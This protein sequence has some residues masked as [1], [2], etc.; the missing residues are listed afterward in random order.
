MWEWHTTHLARMRGAFDAKTDFFFRRSGFFSTKR[1][2]AAAAAARSVAKTHRDRSL[3]SVKKNPHRFCGVR[4]AVTTATTL[5]KGIRALESASPA[6]P[7][8]VAL[9]EEKQ[10]EPLFLAAAPSA[11]GGGAASKDLPAGV[12]GSAQLA[13]GAR[14]AKL[15][16]ECAIVLMH[17]EEDVGNKAYMIEAIRVGVVD[18]VRFPLVAQSMRTLWQHAVRR[19]IRVAARETRRS[20]RPASARASGGGKRAVGGTERRSDRASADSGESTASEEG[21]LKRG[22][23]SPESVLP[24]AAPKSGGGAGTGAA[25]GGKR[26]AGA[27]G[28]SGSGSDKEAD[29]EGAKGKE[30]GGKKS[31]SGVKAGNAAAAA[32][33]P[34]GKPKPQPRS[35]QQWRAAEQRGRRLA[36]KPHTAVVGG[37][38]GVGPGSLNPGAMPG[39]GAM[40]GGGGVYYHTG[41]VGGQPGMAPGAHPHAGVL[42]Q[43][44][45]MTING[46]QVQVWVPMNASGGGVAYGA[47]GQGGRRGGAGD[48]LGSSPPRGEEGEGSTAG[49]GHFYAAGPAGAPQMFHGHP[50]A[51]G[52]MLLVQQA[53]GQQVWVP[54]QPGHHVHSG[55]A[56]GGTHGTQMW[57][58]DTTRVSDADIGTRAD[59]ALRRMEASAVSQMRGACADGIS[60]SLDASGS[61]VRHGGGVPL[62]L[63]L[64]RSD[65]LQQMVESSGLLDGDE[66]NAHPRRGEPKAGGA[67]ASRGGGAFDGSKLE[68]GAMD[69]DM[70]RDAEM[71]EEDAL[72]AILAHARDGNL[73]SFDGMD[74]A[75]LEAAAGPEQGV[76]RA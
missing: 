24:A 42:G 58:E 43:T 30:D 33:G 35:T 75:M 20:E 46:Q 45:T 28:S 7:F 5:E 53:N 15:A 16:S 1:K 25:T 52:G 14:F 73:L 38:A 41:A 3:P 48:A 40:R 67:S 23:S 31:V 57:K 34:A 62:G 63:G 22:A 10:A 55:N 19:M 26:K 50:G 36:I 65:S 32:S 39:G 68:G 49:P 9:L 12:A 51:G 74:E 76:R 17:E 56:T 29:K 71:L 47:P 69:A 8:D 59:G 64:K 72:D 44:Q 11:G 60:G 13:L 66:P 2:N 54:A 6:A 27:T 70:F 4:R 61:T 21:R 18:V 37:V